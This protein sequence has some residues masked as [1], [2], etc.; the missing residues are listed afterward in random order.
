MLKETI[1]K[2][3]HYNI[4][5]N[6]R[7]LNEIVA[8]GDE[9]VDKEIPSSYPSV[10]KT[11]YHIYDA[12]SIWLSRLKNENA[13][14]PASKNFSG[15]LQ[16]FSKVMIAKSNEFA[17]YVESLDEKMLSE[18]FTY[19]NIAGKEFSN[20]RIDSIHHCM[21]HSSQHR[22]QLITMLRIAGHSHFEDMDF[23]IYCREKF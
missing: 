19:K 9:K 17:A 12:E 4:W 11:L 5:A 16:D 23:I 14:W 7:I 21:N 3:T 15:T 10:R 22:G 1:L 20:A 2:Y 18:N 6:Q 8:A 13:T